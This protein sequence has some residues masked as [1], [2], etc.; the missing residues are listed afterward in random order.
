MEYK[1]AWGLPGKHF[2]ADIIN[3][4]IAHRSAPKYAFHP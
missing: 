4:K 2:F 3:R 1:D